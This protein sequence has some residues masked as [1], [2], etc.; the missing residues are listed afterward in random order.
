M[1]FAR[2]I[3]WRAD[4]GRQS[5]ESLDARLSDPADPVVAI[6]ESLNAN[7]FVADAHLNLIFMNRLARESL[8]RLAGPL[9]AAFGLTPDQVLGAPIHRFHNDPSRVDAILAN[10]SAMPREAEFPFGGRIIK[11]MINAIVTRAGER[12][13]FVVLWEDVTDRAADYAAFDAAMDTLNTIS[14]TLV[15]AASS[16]SEYAGAVAVAS[17]QL[18]L[19]VGAI[20]DAT[21]SATQQV[22]E[23][24]EAAAQGLQTMIEL[25][26]SSA[27][28]GDFLRLITGVAEQTKLLALNATIEAARAGSAGRGFAVVADE[29]KQL[30]GTTA[31]SI[32][33][34]EARIEGIQHGAERGAASLRALDQLVNQIRESQNTIAE[35]TNQQS[36]VTVE[37]AQA[38]AQIATD[39][40]RTKDDA[41]QITAAVTHARHK[42][43]RMR[44]QHP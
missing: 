9:R 12:T 37:I 2:A 44:D 39:V 10:P 16:G 36:A 23:A 22:R 28:I 8:G 5:L 1:A 20:A 25:Q 13:G 26:R 30:A 43:V 18:G 7:C 27:E 17:H 3:A 42:T 11:T 34:I 35:A 24:V 40:D 38:V 19:S 4:P 15:Q 41:Q 33:D 21:T 29:V 6:V 14:G 32:S 31:A